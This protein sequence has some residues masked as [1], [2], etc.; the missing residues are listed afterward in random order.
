MPHPEATAS[1]RRPMRPAAFIALLY[2]F[3][4]LPSQSA[5]PGF[6]LRFSA[7]RRH[8][9]DQRGAI[10]EAHDEA[11][12]SPLIYAVSARHADTC[13]ALI[14]LGALLSYRHTPEDSPALRE[15]LRRNYEAASSA[16]RTAHPDIYRVLDDASLELDPLPFSKSWPT[17]LSRRQWPRERFTLS[18]T[19]RIWRH[20][21]CSPGCLASLLICMTGLA[22]GR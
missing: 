10:L 6:P 12:Q 19:A 7:D 21:N 2:G 15:E 20:C 17:V 18:I 9:I 4:V 5:E 22:T 3:T 11:G 16:S 1:T 14:E 8:L 13:A